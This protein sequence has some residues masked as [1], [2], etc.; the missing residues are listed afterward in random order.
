MEE[1]RICYPSVAHWE[2]RTCQIRLR[3]DA[4]GEEGIMVPISLC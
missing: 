1:G 3:S 4:L 2:R